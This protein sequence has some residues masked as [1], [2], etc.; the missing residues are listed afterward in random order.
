MVALPHE[1][2]VFHYHPFIFLFISCD[3]ITDTIHFS[4][5]EKSVTIN[6]LSS[7]NVTKVIFDESGIHRGSK[8]RL[9][10]R[11]ALRFFYKKKFN[12]IK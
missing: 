12:K 9:H 6:K 10:D 7:N 5:N 4:K 8:T 1:K 11:M 2:D 3:S